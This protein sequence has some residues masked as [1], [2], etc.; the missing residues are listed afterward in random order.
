[1][2]FDLELGHFDHSSEIKAQKFAENF[3]CQIPAFGM[4][5]TQYIQVIF[6]DI[7]ASIL[8]LNQKIS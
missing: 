5:K 2:L 8:Q 7:E 3:W 1:M 6:N 4:Q